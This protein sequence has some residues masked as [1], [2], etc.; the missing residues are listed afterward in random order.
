M[1]LKII[2]AGEILVLK[3]CRKLFQLCRDGIPL[4]YTASCAHLLRAMIQLN[5]MAFSNLN[6]SMKAS[7]FKCNIKPSATPLHS[8]RALHLHH[9]ICL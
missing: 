8:L 9:I 6:D 4:L 1:A 3:S 7:V 2:L 5:L